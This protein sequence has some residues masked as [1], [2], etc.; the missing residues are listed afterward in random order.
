[1]SKAE[2]IQ[3]NEEEKKEILPESKDN[4]N[5]DNSKGANKPI[6]K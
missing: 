5:Y 6:T 1:M 2:E 3:N 4:E